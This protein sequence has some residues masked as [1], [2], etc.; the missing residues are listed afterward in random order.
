MAPPPPPP[1]AFE[2]PTPL[3]LVVESADADRGVLARIAQ[4]CGL[5]VT[6]VATGAAAMEAAEQKEPDVVLLDVHLP[7]MDGL[8]VLAQLRV[9]H[10]DLPVIVIAEPCEGERVEAALEVGALNYLCKPVNAREVAF[11]LDRLQRALQEEAGLQAPLQTVQERRTALQ[12][13]CDLDLI[14][15][16]VLLLGREAT[17]H[18]PGYRIPV[19]DIKLALYEALANAVEHGNLE[20]DFEGKAEALMDPGGLAD[21]IR[22]RRGDPRFA[23]RVVQIQ[24]IYR[25]AEVE[26]RVRDEGPGFDPMDFCPKKALG[27]VEALHGRGLALIR[28]YMDEVEWNPDGNEIRMSR[29]LQRRQRRSS[30]GTSS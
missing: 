7:D 10:P 24:V 28:H 11:V 17:C 2:T 1:P 26:Y 3:A 19:A 12:L 13:P 15:G 29:R 14:P 22:K 8:Q 21:L 9:D 18:Y 4:D 23:E 5:E 20:I 30:N 16:V 6:E 25:P 27:N